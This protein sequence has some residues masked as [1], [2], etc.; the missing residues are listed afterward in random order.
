M[1]N[2]SSMLSPGST[3]ARNRPALPVVTVFP[4]GP[5]RI[6]LAWMPASELGLNRHA[7]S[8]VLW[9][10]MRYKN[11]LPDGTTTS[12]LIGSRRHHNS[13]GQYSF[14]IHCRK[15][16]EE[17]RAPLACSHSSYKSKKRSRFAGRPRA[18]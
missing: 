9:A 2:D 6:Y 8:D 11:D 7:L 18:T 12:S 15:R 4:S 3:V 5:H 13:P 17:C 10:R 16:A 1:A 14:V